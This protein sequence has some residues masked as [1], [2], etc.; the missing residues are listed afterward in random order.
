MPKKISDAP[1]SENAVSTIHKHSLIFDTVSACNRN[2][3]QLVIE[4][5]QA[6]FLE[7]EITLVFWPDTTHILNLL[8]TNQRIQN[9]YNIL[10]KE[11]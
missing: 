8:K 1:N 9:L 2:F 3:T 6:V 11:M 7:K 10:V 5:E 4:T